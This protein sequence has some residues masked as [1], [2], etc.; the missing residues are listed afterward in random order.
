MVGLF[1]SRNGGCGLQKE[2]QAPPDTAIDVDV[3]LPDNTDFFRARISVSL[4]GLDREWALA[5]VNEAHLILP[6]SRNAR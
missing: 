5:T 1:R 6:L 4:P 3:D 2:N